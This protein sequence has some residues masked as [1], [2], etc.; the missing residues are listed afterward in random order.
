MERVL[1]D[2]ERLEVAMNFVFEEDLDKYESICSY[3]E[4]T[5]CSVDEAFDHVMGIEN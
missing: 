1:T 4:K 2:A 5:G 3:A